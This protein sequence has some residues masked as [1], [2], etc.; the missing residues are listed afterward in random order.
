[1]LPHFTNLDSVASVVLILTTSLSASTFSMCPRPR[2]QLFPQFSELC[3]V[4][5]VSSM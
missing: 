4:V 5:E 1:M 2:T 3:A